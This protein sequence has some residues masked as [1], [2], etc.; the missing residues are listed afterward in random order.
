MILKYTFIKYFIE[1][2]QKDT[3]AKDVTKV[4]YEPKLLTFEEEL[5]KIMGI[6]EPRKRAKTHWY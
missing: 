5:N 3:P 6:E 1:N 2:T 4:T